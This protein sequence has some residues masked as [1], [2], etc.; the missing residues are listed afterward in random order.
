[1][2][3]LVSCTTDGSAPIAWETIRLR[4]RYS[5]SL[6]SSWQAN[7]SRAE[8]LERITALQHTTFSLAQFL[9]GSCT[10]HCKHSCR[11]L[12]TYRAPSRAMWWMVTFRSY[13]RSRQDCLSPSCQAAACS[14]CFLSSIFWPEF[15]SSTSAGTSSVPS[16][17]ARR[18]HLS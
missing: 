15:T 11:G 9:T 6:L 1:M 12:Q 7:V 13:G 8:L 3:A 16:L 17:P 10:L 4:K 2:L 5:P 14:V 18:W